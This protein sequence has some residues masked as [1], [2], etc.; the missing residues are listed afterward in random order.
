[1]QHR[2]ERRDPVDHGGVDHLA[3]PGQPALVQRGEDAEREVGAAAAEVGQQVQRRQRRRVGRA[4]REH[5]ARDRGV[6][7]VVA[8]LGGPRPRLPPAG[9]PA[10]DQARVDAPAARQVRGRASRRRPG[11]MP[12]RNTSARLDQ[13]QQHRP[14]RGAAQVDPDPP[15]PPGARVV[16]QRQ[17]GERP[18]PARAVHPGHLGAEIAQQHHREG[19]RPEGCS[20]RR[21]VTSP[22]AWAAGP[23][24]GRGAGPR[25]PVLPLRVAALAERGHALGGVREANTG[26]R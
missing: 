22:S 8:R 21:R 16:L 18:G 12:S 4:E 19:N 15:V 9:G 26:S 11:R 1:M 6:V 14:A 17:P 2:G 24:A 25:S 10:V 13:P 5:A 23:V 20:G 3:A 7:D